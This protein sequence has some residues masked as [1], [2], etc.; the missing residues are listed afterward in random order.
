MAATLRWRELEARDVP[1]LAALAGRCLRAD[2]GSPDAATASF[3]DRSYLLPGKSTLGAVEPGGQVVAAA[4][5]RR[6]QDRL[7]AVG[8]VDPAWRGRGLG[9]ELFGWTCA[10][11]G[12]ACTLRILTEAVTPAAE[13]LYARYHLVQV[14]A[15]DVMRRDLT[16]P[17]PDIPLPAGVAVEAWSDRVV[18]D[19][20][21]AY[22]GSFGDRPGFPGW[23][24]EQWVAWTVDEE[25][26]PDLSMVARSADGPVG[27][28]TCT[29][30]LI[31]QV[32]VRPDWRGRRLGAALVAGT[33]A[34]MR[35]TGTTQCHL[36]V[37]VDNP[38]AARLY[39]RL[40]FVPIGRR[41]R[42]EANLPA[43]RR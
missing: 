37:N 2:G 35:A 8:Q 31:V 23:T 9:R 36:D 20:F 30:D 16:V 42:Y 22:A 15:E 13:R 6:N 18:A 19:F 34:T 41:A 4:A 38:G 21:A 12:D 39:R 28:L 7:D 14:F 10:Q 27:F 29:A 24:L 40:G 25:F 26:R 32:G 1:L 5:A 11:G 3:V 33:L 43:A 17:L